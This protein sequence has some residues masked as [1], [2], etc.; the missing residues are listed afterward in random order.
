[1]RLAVEAGAGAVHL[2]ELAQVQLADVHVGLGVD[3]GGPRADTI[4]EAIISLSWVKKQSLWSKLRARGGRIIS[5]C[6]QLRAKAVFLYPRQSYDI[7]NTG[8]G[9]GSPDAHGAVVSLGDPLAE[10]VRVGLRALPHPDEA[11]L[12]VARTSYRAAQGRTG[13]HKVV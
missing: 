3:P 7:E 11:H 8:A 2:D 5:A 1:V 4:M 6:A 12:C 9:W 13:S 10:L